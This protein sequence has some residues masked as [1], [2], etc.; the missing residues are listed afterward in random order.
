MVFLSSVLGLKLVEAYRFAVYLHLGTLFSAILYYRDDIINSIKGCGFSF[1]NSLLRLWITT[2]VVSVVTGYPM[3]ITYQRILG[4]VNLDVV[5]GVIGLLLIVTGLLLMYAKSKRNYRVFKDLNIKDYIAL[6][7]AQG[8]SII[9]GISR[10]GVTIAIL[11]LLGLHSSDAVKT[12]FLASIPIIALASLYTG[13][14]QGYIISTIGLTGM[15]SAF[16]A[17]LMGLWVMVFISRKL[18]L[19]Y[20]T[21]ILGLIMFLASTPL[22]I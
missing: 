5:T 7:I 9:P 22:T 17:G 1:N 4:N 12:S 6:G 18:P 16:G 13:L 3:Y 8:T 20:F 11:L 10:S 21:L 15:L 19:H 14:S 2:T